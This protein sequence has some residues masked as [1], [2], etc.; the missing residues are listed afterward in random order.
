MRNCTL[1]V[2]DDLRK[3]KAGT[4]VW[5]QTEDTDGMY[6]VSTPLETDVFF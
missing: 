2:T 3:C 5:R 6:T 1:Y 4:G